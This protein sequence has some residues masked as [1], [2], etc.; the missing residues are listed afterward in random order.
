MVFLR[1]DRNNSQPSYFTATPSKWT[2]TPRFKRSTRRWWT[3]TSSEDSRAGVALRH[4]PD[5]AGCDGG[6]YRGYC[7]ATVGAV[8]LS[9]PRELLLGGTVQ[10]GDKGLEQAPRVARCGDTPAAV[11]LV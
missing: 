9:K 10:V 8:A 11:L 2:L 4:S 5:I 3:A 7:G 6:S 1:R